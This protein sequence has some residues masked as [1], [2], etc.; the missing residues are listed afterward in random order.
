MC[1][2]YFESLYQ[3]V[4]QCKSVVTQ[5]LL[6]VKMPGRWR[7][8]DLLFS[9]LMPVLLRSN[10]HAAVCNYGPVCAGGNIHIGT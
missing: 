8:V 6:L 9:Q 2:W 5:V 7:H 10:S 3:S 4:W 1:V